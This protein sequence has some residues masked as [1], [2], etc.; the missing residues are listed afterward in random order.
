MQ[1]EQLP[2]YVQKES[3]IN[4][5][6]ENQVIVIEAPTGSGKTTQIPQIL[7]QSADSFTREN[8]KQKL[9]RIG[10]TQPRRI[11]AISVAKRIAFEMNIQPGDLVGYKMRFSD[12]TTDNTCIKIMTDG[13]LLQELRHDPLLKEYDIIMVDEAHERSLNIDFILGLLKNILVQRPSFK[14]IISSATIN[15]KVFSEY[16]HDCPII[17]IEAKA[18]PV[19]IIYRNVKGHE[20]ED[21]INMAVK[22]AREIINNYSQGDILIFMPGEAA[23]KKTINLLG[24][25]GKYNLQFLPL[26]SQLSAEDQD[27]VF[28]EYPGSRKVIVTT[29]IAE[30]S[31]TID[32]IVYIIDT[33]LCKLNSYNPST[34]TS[35][36]VLSKISRA[37]CKQRKGRAGRTQK[38]YCYRLF[39]SEDYKNREKFTT[40]EI[41][42]RDLTEVILRMADLGINNYES[43]DFI[44]PPGPSSI[45]SAIKTLQMLDALDEHKKIT[46]LGK[47]MAVFPLSPRIS[48]ILLEAIK[49][50]PDVVN[51]VLILASFIST[52]N[53]Y[54]LPMGKENISR[55][56][57]AKLSHSFGDFTTWIKLFNRYN[58]HSNK[59][60]FCNTFYLDKK[61][62]D[63][64]INIH[65]QLIRIVYDFGGEIG[66]GGI[67]KH[68]MLAVLTGLYQ[69]ICRK[70]QRGNSYSSI[71]ENNIYIHPGSVLFGKKVLY[72]VSGEIINT[73]KTYSRS[74]AVIEK[75][76]IRF[77]SDK[78]YKKLFPEKSR[79]RYRNP[80][81][82][83]QNRR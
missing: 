30:T 21:Y 27:K 16:F 44:A 64:I 32:G 18:F 33:G 71:T 14:I 49:N 57:H 48:R 55:R 67:Y 58:K 62:M 83:F 5:V 29:N 70:N 3:I 56:M 35:S 17:S 31:I 8:N 15:A 80:N 77:T 74:T 81:R 54:L 53:P 34:F 2:V 26:Y 40:E 23:I 69:N 76:W 37:S 73:R 78:I 60:E 47:Q 19:D 51:E 7:Y 46:E 68:L 63:E 24:K 11:A 1:R 42:R 22:V 79:E 12:I 61:V 43:F 13:I 38:G 10:V 20:E 28:Q 52:K 25:K 45:R 66:H 36:L 39:S 6:K 9:F 4:A 59:E 82:K 41:H 65:S 72:I 75:G 50:Y